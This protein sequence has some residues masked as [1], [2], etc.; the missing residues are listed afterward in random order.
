MA[1]VALMAMVPI[2]SAVGNGVVPPAP[3]AS[4]IRKYPPA[5]T[6]PVRFVFC[7]VVPALEA[8]CTDQPVTD[9]GAA[10]G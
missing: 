4:W 5:G 1:P 9:T 10:P 6:V 8:Y 2:V 7:Q 3:A